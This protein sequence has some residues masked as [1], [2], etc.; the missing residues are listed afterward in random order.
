VPR[1]KSTG[2]T[3]RE[4]EIIAILWNLGDAG[5]EDIRQRLSGNPTASTVRTL[6][7]IMAGRGLVADDGSGYGKRYRARAPQADVQASALRRLIDTL[8]AGSTE[9]MLLRLMD[10]EEIDIDRLKEIQ[11]RLKERG[12]T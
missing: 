12:E 3:E 1:K 2:L 9:A 10:R 8:F 5:V 7:G 4:A 6:L 11:Q